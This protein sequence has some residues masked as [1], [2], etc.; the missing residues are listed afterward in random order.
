MA[1]YSLTRKAERIYQV[2]GT[3]L[4]I[5]GQRNKLIYTTRCY[6]IIART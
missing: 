1:N 3:I 4:M 6:L 2:F 5:I